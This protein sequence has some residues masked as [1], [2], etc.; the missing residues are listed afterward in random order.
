MFCII[1]TGVSGVKPIA[2]ARLTNRCP[3]FKPLTTAV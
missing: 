3:P 2:D 1:V